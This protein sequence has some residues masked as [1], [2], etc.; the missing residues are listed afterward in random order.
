MIE[1]GVEAVARS[2]EATAL[3]LWEVLA[4]VPRIVGVLRRLLRDLEAH[5]GALV[6]TID[7]PELMLRL[8][9]V[10][11]R[12]GHRVVHWV[13]PQV[14]AWR[15][16]RVR[17]LS[18]SVDEVL[19]LLP[20]EEAILA[21]HVPAT[22][23]GHPAA[24]IRLGR[25]V[26]PG[27]PTFA[28]VPG[29]RPSEVRRTWPLMR[30]VARGLRRRHPVAGF[31]V[32]RAPTIPR[33]MLGGLDAVLVDTMSD[34]VG[35]D[36]ALTA[37]GTATLELGALGVPMVV[38]YRVH[39][40]TYALARRLVRVEHIALPN[41]LASR[42]LVPEFVQALD[43]VV[44]A[45]AVDRARGQERLPAELLAS[46]GGESAIDRVADVVAAGLRAQCADVIPPQPPR[47]GIGV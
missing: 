8:G 1:A 14:W 2:E 30:E 7:S 34:A 28:L 44:I 12:R 36:A 42:P 29:S 24:G 22:F 25:A 41:L 19:C 13:A 40:I 46:L 20:F 23:T 32:V 15:R 43:P 9:A 26:R 16:G 3:G 45:E 47:G 18:R 10:A 27:D 31:V 38:V 37:S 35:A 21:P 5:P 11:K 4:S 33:E 6:L 17:G 39:P